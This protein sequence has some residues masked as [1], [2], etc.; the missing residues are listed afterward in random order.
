MISVELANNIIPQN[1]DKLLSFFSKNSEES[2]INNLFNYSNKYGYSPGCYLKNNNEI[3]G[4]LGTIYS[5]REINNN[6]LIFCNLSFLYVKK[7]YRIH[8]LK[9]IHKILNQDEIVFTFLTPNEISHK[10]IKYFKG[11]ILEDSMIVFFPLPFFKFKNKLMSIKDN[12]YLN[13]SKEDKKHFLAHSISKSK[14]ILFRYKNSYC[15]IISTI[16][17]KHIPITHVQYISNKMLFYEFRYY[18]NWE[19]AKTN[20][21]FFTIIDKRFLMNKKVRISFLYKLKTPKF[22]KS[23]VK[24]KKMEID[25]LYSDLVLLNYFMA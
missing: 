22:Y 1:L 3:V 8:S 16:I 24:F 7:E 17:K 23:N 11:S 25:N 12:F 14:H 5:K 6:S 15:Y 20:K 19:L 18:I 13:L 2:I 9:L 21:T 4:F 10:I